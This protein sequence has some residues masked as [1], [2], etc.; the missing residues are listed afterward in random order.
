MQDLGN[1]QRAAHVQAEVGHGIGW[2]GL[3]ASVERIRSGIQRG[4]RQLHEHGAGVSGLA[5]PP[6]AEAG[7]LAVVRS[8][9]V[10]GVGA[11]AAAPESAPATTTTSSASSA[12]AHSTAGA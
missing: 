5:A 10:V 3:G 8:A 7:V 1:I 4:V 6:V 2:L 11:C 9:P 12:E